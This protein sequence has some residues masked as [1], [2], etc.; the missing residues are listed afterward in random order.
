ML[1]SA[2]VFVLLVAAVGAPFLAPSS[3]FKTN[4]VDRLQSPSRNHL[5][6][7]DAVGRDVFSRVLYGARISIS[8]AAAVIGLAGPFG[9]LVGAIAGFRRGVID[10]VLMRVTDIFFAFP[11]LLL[12]MAI[13]AALGAS[14]P[15]AII[16]VT[17]VWWP[18]YA[19]LMRGQV[20]AL[21]Q[22]LYVE[23]AQALGASNF[24]ILWRHITPNAILPLVVKVTNDV[25]FTILTVAGLSFIGL[26]VQPPTPEWGAMVA[27]GRTFMLDYWWYATF[28]GLAIALTVL[29]FAFLG[30][31]LQE[32]LD[33]RLRSP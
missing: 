5:F 13:N 28:P 25:G 7:T 24:R 17:I 14:L 19:R 23:A 8:I 3:P 15:N 27:D 32:V 9:M 26:G 33:P 30:D 31:S 22:E 20:L 4:I 6:G 16:A 1:S 2:F 21:R 11:S 29:S 12:A 10:T 18:S